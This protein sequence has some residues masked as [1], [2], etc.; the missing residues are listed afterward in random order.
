MKLFTVGPTQ[1]FP[2]TLDVASRQIPYFRNEAFSSVVKEC[3]SLLKQFAHAPADSRVVFLTASGTGA[4]EATV[5]NCMSE[6]DKALVIEGGSFGHRFAQLCA[7]HGIPYD[8]VK[9]G[10]DEGLRADHLDPFD[11]GHYTALLVNADET[12]TGQLYDLGMLAEFCRRNGMLFI[13]DAISSFAADEIDMSELGIDALIVSSQK[14]LS[15]APGLS[16]VVLARRMIEDRVSKI[17][18]RSMYFDFK[19]H[20]KNGERGQ[21]PFT[22]AVGIVHELHNRLRL[23]EDAGGISSE[24]ERVAR[25]ADDFRARIAC[26]PLSLPPYPLSNALT[27]VVFNEPVAEKVNAALV[28]EFGMVSNPCG[29][30]LARWSLRFAHIGDLTVEDNAALADAL[31]AVLQRM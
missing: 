14:A 26:E 20:L 19:D 9:L 23:I 4:M 16:F 6:G 5:T 30:D 3:E 12:S 10:V 18:P 28:N 31:H 8:S 11:N 15:L 25:L 29:G 17:D 1:M 27:R 24:I 21:T 13:V 7:I 2:Q 22:P